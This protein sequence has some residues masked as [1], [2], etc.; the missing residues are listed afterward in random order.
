MLCKDHADP[1]MLVLHP[2]G[3]NMAAPRV[4]NQPKQ[5]ELEA[6]K[7]WD[8]VEQWVEKYKAAPIMDAE[9]YRWSF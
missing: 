9:Q 4:L 1:G 7:E 6:L 3:N 2:E 5:E 8:L